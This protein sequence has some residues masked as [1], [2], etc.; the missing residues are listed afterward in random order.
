MISIL[1]ATYNRYD[2]LKECLES[3]KNQTYKDIEVVVVDDGSEDDTES[4]C[5]D[6]VYKKIPHTGISAARN[7]AMRLAKGDIFMVVDSDDTLEPTCVEKEVAMLDKNDMTFCDV[8]IVSRDRKAIIG[9]FGA[10]VQ[11]FKQCLSVKLIPHPSLMFKRWVVDGIWYDESLTSAV[12]YDFTL[13]ILKKWPNLKIVLLEEPLYNYRW[14]GDQESFY[15]R[16][17]ENAMRIKEKY[18]EFKI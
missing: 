6:V 14:H 5:K 2:Y 4:L 11:D 16:Q 10:K 15:P 12:D 17:G 13:K 8:V 18:D 7:E 1:I 3:I 9:K